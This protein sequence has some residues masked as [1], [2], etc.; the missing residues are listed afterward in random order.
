ML[1]LAGSIPAAAQSD[2]LKLGPDALKPSLQ[3]QP[4]PPVVTI[5]PAQPQS[6]PIATGCACVETIDVPIY[7]NGRVVG[8]NRINRP[9]GR[10]AAACCR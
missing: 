1:S 9:T 4:A 3:P 5:K 10:N 7:Q 8:F 6:A 2:Q